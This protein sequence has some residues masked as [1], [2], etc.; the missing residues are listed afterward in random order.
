[1]GGLAG[2]RAGRGRLSRPLIPAHQE[3]VPTWTLGAI[4]ALPP[5]PQRLCGL[6]GGLMHAH[7]ELLP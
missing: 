1:M 4:L 7:L 5:G 6:E 2:G 3:G